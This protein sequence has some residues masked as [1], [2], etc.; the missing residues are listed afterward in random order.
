MNPTREGTL[1]ESRA[2]GYRAQAA[3]TRVNHAEKATANVALA[4]ARFHTFGWV[5][6]NDQKT[7][8]GFLPD[9]YS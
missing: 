1:V 9:L 7:Y 2:P 3:K 5:A 8:E 4:D 6:E